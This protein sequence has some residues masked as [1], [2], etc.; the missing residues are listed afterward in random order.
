MV[1]PPPFFAAAPSKP[2][3]PY[4]ASTSLV[5]YDN[6]S[7]GITFTWSATGVTY[8]IEIA[9]SSCF[10]NCGTP[11]TSTVVNSSYGFAGNTYASS[12]GYSQATTYYWHVQAYDVSANPSGWSNT[13]SFRTAITPPTLLTPANT[14]TL[15]NNLNNDNTNTPPNPLFTWIDVPYATQYVLQVSTSSTFGSFILNVTL[16]NSVASYT[17]TKDLPVNNGA[18]IY[19]RVEALDGAYGPSPSDTWYFYP[20]TPSTVPVLLQ[21]AT[22]KITNDYT[23]GLLWNGVTIPGSTTFSYYEV[24][25]S[26]NSTFVDTTK[27]CVD[28]TSD[29]INQFD[30]NQITASL[31]MAVALASASPGINCPT[32]VYTG[33]GGSV[34]SLGPADTYYWRVR[35]VTSGGASD[36]S[37]IFSFLT[38]Y[39]K[40]DATTFNVTP[41][42]GV[43]TPTHLTYNFPTFTWAPVVPSPSYYIIQ[44]ANN[45]GFSGPLVNIHTGSPSYMITSK[46]KQLPPGGVTLYW[47]VS[48]ASTTYGQGLWSDPGSF[49]TASPPSIPLVKSPKNNSV[50]PTYTPTLIWGVSGFP[51]AST[52]TFGYYEVEVDISTAFAA[53]IVDDTSSTNQ[54]APFFTLTTPLN[55]ST[56]YYWRVQACNSLVPPDCSPWSASSFRTIVAVPTGLSSSGAFPDVLS[57]NPVPYAT[58]SVQIS[59]S[60][61]FGKGT[62]TKSTSISTIT[63]PS[64]P[65]GYWRV[66]SMTKNF[67]SS[68]W[69]APQPL[70]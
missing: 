39:L 31:D 8:D 68:G 30:P 44:I 17:P 53:P 58:Y 38:S 35:A 2:G 59:T 52:A 12:Y 25:V 61:S 33:G 23:P 37:T 64:G 21:P 6:Y 19:W 43:S 29:A 57:W 14:T 55:S 54:Y 10:T 27:L 22:G 13:F 49:T 41:N 5:T 40:V 15:V 50:V 60:V 16:A 70:P 62:I 24:Q 9:T 48:A 32:F 4:P 1:H 45:P 11:P 18:P 28:N 69:S 3:S 65:T 46:T 36:W 56:V 47:R 26:T 63:I 66:R 42:D 7:S 20:A 67:G 51:K 34:T